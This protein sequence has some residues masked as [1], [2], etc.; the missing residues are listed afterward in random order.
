M[1]T[2]YFKYLKVGIADVT[3]MH[4]IMAECKTYIEIVVK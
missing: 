4:S 3:K 2:L 1:S